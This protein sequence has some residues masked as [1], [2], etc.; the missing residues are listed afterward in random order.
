MAKENKEDLTK[1]RILDSAETLFAQ[2]GFRA[3]SVREITSA[4]RCNLAAVNYHFGNKESLYL[5]VFRS[6]WVP[7]ARRVQE[8]FRKSLAAQDSTSPEAVVS[9]LAKA[10]L[11][12]PLSDEERLRHS[13]LMTREMT[14]PTKAFEHVAEQIMQPFFQELADKLGSV[15]PNELEEEKMLL[16][17][18]SIFG[19]VLYFNFARVAV[20]R[21]TGEK[22]NAAFRDRLVKQI[23]EFSLKGLNVNDEEELQ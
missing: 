19:M 6:R 18:F 11:E 12:G 2:K 20:S 16:N 17:I 1:E 7:R 4:A 9:A 5:E 15:L 14:Q 13:Q 10:F 8:S 22:Y 21:L 3:V 23:T